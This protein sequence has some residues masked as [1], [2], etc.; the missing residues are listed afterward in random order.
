MFSTVLR[1]SKHEYSIL[2][3]WNEKIQCMLKLT[4]K[5]LNKILQGVAYRET[6]T[7][8]IE[9]KTPQS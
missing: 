3:S 4:W 5:K 6:F 9:N 2:K 8:M 1:K 7:W